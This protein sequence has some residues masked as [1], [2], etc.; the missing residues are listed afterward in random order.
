MANYIFSILLLVAV[1]L[2]LW[3]NTREMYLL[4]AAL[5]VINSGL[6]LASYVRSNKSRGS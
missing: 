6:S 5:I 4:L 1:G 2:A 3:F